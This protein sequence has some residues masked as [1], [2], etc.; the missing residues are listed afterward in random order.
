MPLSALEPRRS[1]APVISGRFL[2]GLETLRLFLTLAVSM[3]PF[4]AR[5]LLSYFGL[6]RHPPTRP[7]PNYL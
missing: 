5:F 3:H 2:S 1:C 6:F 7:R 4:T